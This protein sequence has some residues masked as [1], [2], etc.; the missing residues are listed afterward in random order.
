MHVLAC[1]VVVVA[2]RL[3]NGP[4]AVGGSDSFVEDSASAIRAKQKTREKQE[5][6]TEPERQT[7]RFHSE[8]SA[9]HLTDGR[10]TTA[11]GSFENSSAPTIGNVRD[12]VREARLRGDRQVPLGHL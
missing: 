10:K 11:S 1:S 8:D 9:T 3:L 6:K 7:N 2:S 5:N 4:G 12:T